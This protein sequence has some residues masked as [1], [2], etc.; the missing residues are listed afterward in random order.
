MDIIKIGNFIR[1]CRKN[2]NLNQKQLAD[3]LF[4]EP[5][6][7]S[8]WET[9]NGLPDVSIMKKLCNELEISLSELFLGE[10]I[11]EKSNEIITEKI[12]LEEIK[13]E[14]LQNK[15]NLIGEILIGCAFIAV[16]II[17][18]LFIGFAPI[19]TYLK[20]I[21]IALA[22]IFI[23]VGVVGLVILDANIGYFECA[24]CHERFIPSVKDYT[25]GLHTLKKRRLTCPRCGK[26]TWCCKKM[27]K[28]DL[29]D[30]T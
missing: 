29:D 16:I 28:K 12:L 22:F 27:I 15:K 18:I 23:V 13:K 19:A 3:K 14:G 25:F 8:K 10:H 11:K 5:K 9:G 4:V 24:E 1:E 7:I 21:L 17:L 2:K 30:L 6:T 26:K 20:I